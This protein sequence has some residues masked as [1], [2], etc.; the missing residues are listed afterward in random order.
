MALVG[1][2]DYPLGIGT[3]NGADYVIN[4]K[5]TSSANYTDNIKAKIEELTGGSMAD[6][7]IVPTSS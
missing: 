4:I 3:K 5:D 2:R 7:V 1:T 6:K